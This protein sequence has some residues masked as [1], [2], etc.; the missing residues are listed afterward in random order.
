MLRGSRQ[1]RALFHL[2]TFTCWH[3]AHL[4]VTVF[5]VWKLVL[6]SVVALAPG[7]GYDTSSTLLVS[8]E[9]QGTSA[10]EIREVATS[11]PSALKFVRWDAI[12]FSQ[13]TQRGYIFEQEW[14]FG[15]SLPSLVDL[16]QKGVFHLF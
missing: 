5:C 12:Y 13:I 14:A 6:L 3:D 15:P 1:E 9:S 8:T 7:P 2:R 10:T 16:L 4:L 11:L